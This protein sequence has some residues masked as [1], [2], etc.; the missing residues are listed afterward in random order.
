MIFCH[1]KNQIQ[2]IVLLCGFVINSQTFAENQVDNTI[3]SSTLTIIPQDEMSL[4]AINF[5]KKAL[6]LFF[7]VDSQNY[8]ASFEK[9]KPF[10]SPETFNKMKFDFK[11][12]TISELSLNQAKSDIQFFPNEEVIVEYNNQK[13]IV[14]YQ[15]KLPVRLTQK[16]IKAYQVNVDI[17]VFLIK[18]NNSFL[19]KNVIIN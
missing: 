8:E 9:A 12:D 10:F 7:N 2:L 15:I 14:G 4:N 1:K 3:Y 16:G 11:E 19:I 5:S 17:H 6:K 13:E 18:N